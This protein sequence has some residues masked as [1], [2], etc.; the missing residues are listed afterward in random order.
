MLR[1]WCTDPERIV[2]VN[3]HTELSK[4][5]L[6]ARSELI[7]T[8]SRGIPSVCSG[9]EKSSSPRPACICHSPIN[10]V[11]V[12]ALPVQ[13][14]LVSGPNKS[15]STLWLLSPDFTLLRLGILASHEN[16]IT[17]C[18]LTIVAIIYHGGISQNP[19]LPYYGTTLGPAH[20]GLA[21]HLN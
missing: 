6:D 11:S 20:D 15:S 9:N 16:T 10:F 3:P 7:D 14:W 1:Q 21:E 19:D 2:S 13:F 18:E 17:A 12:V 4:F 5:L 8:M